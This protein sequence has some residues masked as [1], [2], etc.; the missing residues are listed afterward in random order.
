MYDISISIP[1]R[2]ESKDV[3]HFDRFKIHCI[4]KSVNISIKQSAQSILI[5][6]LFK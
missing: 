4:S 5:G 1:V 6:F 3:H 2:I